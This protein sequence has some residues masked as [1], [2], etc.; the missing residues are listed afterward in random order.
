[1]RQESL[2]EG[3]NIGSSAK[4]KI[5]LPTSVYILRWE[6][7]GKGMRDTGEALVAEDS[8]LAVLSLIVYVERMAVR[9]E[10]SV[11]VWHQRQ[12]D[13]QLLCSQECCGTIGISTPHSDA[14][15]VGAQALPG[16]Q[17]HRLTLLKLCVTRSTRRRTVAAD[18]ILT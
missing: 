13:R 18:H 4:G 15:T 16:S 2:G 10:E 17:R 3:C 1:M 9:T 12:R 5:L 7:P 11:S 14:L 6:Q 8:H